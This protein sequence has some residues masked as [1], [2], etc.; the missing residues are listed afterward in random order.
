[1]Q[2]FGAAAMLAGSFWYVAV[3]A[4]WL[5]RQFGISLLSATLASARCFAVA[6]GLIVAIGAFLVIAPPP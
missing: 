2:A 6:T 4:E 1:M 3:N 5:R